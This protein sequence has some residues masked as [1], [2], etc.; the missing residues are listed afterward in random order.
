VQ[1]SISQGGFV[2]AAAVIV[3]PAEQVVIGLDHSAL[4]GTGRRGLAAA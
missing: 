2:G 3:Y 1:F 4:E